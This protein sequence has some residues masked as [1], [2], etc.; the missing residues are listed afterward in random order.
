MFTGFASENTPAIQVWDCSQLLPDAGSVRLVTLADDCAPIQFFKT[1]STTTANTIRVYLPTAPIN[2]R[3]I[4]IVNQS[5]NSSPQAISVFSSD[6]SG[7]GAAVNSFLYSVGTGDS[8]VL[9][10]SIQNITS[11][12]S[13]QTGWTTLNKASLSALNPNALVVGG[14]T[15]SA[16]ST[17][18]F[19]GGGS[20]NTASGSWSTVIGGSNNTASGYNASVFGGDSNNV[21]DN[22]SSVIGGYSNSVSNTGSGIFCGDTNTAS[23]SRVA[24]L[25]GSN[26]TAS[27]PNASVLCGFL[28]TANG[29][30][31]AVIGG[32]GGTNRS[33]VGAITSA[34][35]VIPVANG[36]GF[37]QSALLVLGVQTTNATATVLRSNTSAATTTNQVILPNNSAYYFEGSIVCGVTGGGNSSAWKL[38]GLIKR[39]ANAAST[40]IVQS[41]VN[42][43]GQNSGASTWLVGLS[44]DTTNGGLAITV[45][46]QAA[47]TI[48]WV[49]QIRTTEMT[50]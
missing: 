12:G 5:Y 9:V 11:S 38:E 33:I 23:S 19:V 41:V 20:G 47:T 49:C 45:T 34:A 31:G 13:T 30:H 48:R 8:L 4:T 21:T 44:A 3:Q 10:Y 1:G 14:N 16:S 2:G 7:N 35:S 17:N 27:A 36:V 6:R 32:R 15:N 43:V 22:Y 39:G 26:N 25:G 40:V 37:S 46:G 24:V 18:A 50:Y 29:D 28:N 42:L